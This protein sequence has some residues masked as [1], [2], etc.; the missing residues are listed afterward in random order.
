VYPS[1]ILHDL[2]TVNAVV[3]GGLGRKELSD[4]DMNRVLFI[5]GLDSV[6]DITTADVASLSSRAG[7][8]LHQRCS[9]PGGFSW[10]RACPLELLANEWT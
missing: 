2:T 9:V 7:G 5:V 8:I 10:G 6:N 1:T 3:R 4:A